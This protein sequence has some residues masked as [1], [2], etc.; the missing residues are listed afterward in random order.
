[1]TSYKPPNHPVYTTIIS[2]DSN[3]DVEIIAKDCFVRNTSSNLII[4]QEGSIT[5][6][7]SELSIK[8]QRWIDIDGKEHAKTWCQKCLD[9]GRMCMV[10]LFDLKLSVLAN[11]FESLQGCNIAN[12][13]TTVIAEMEHNKYVAKHKHA[14]EMMKKIKA[15][16]S[17]YFQLEGRTKQCVLALQSYG[18]GLL[19]AVDDYREDENWKTIAWDLERFGSI[20]NKLQEVTNVHA[21]IELEAEVIKKTAQEEFKSVEEKLMKAE[22]GKLDRGD[23]AFTAMMATPGLG[24]VAGAVYGAY[25]GAVGSYHLLDNLKCPA[26]ARVPLQF[27]AGGLGGLVGGT[28]YAIG[29]VPLVPFFLYNTL[30]G[31]AKVQ[32]SDKYETL[33][34]KFITIGAQMEMV[35]ARIKE[36]INALQIIDQKFEKSKAAEEKLNFRLNQ[37]MS[38]LDKQATRIEGTAKE[39]ISA[40][41]HYLA[42]VNRDMSPDM[43]SI[44]YAVGWENKVRKINNM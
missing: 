13:L 29:S 33:A 35:S 30:N 32:K 8:N 14:E 39:L 15:L 42:L 26:T 34:Q 2:I 4:T 5:H 37:G 17:T 43:K 22:D 25:G 20:K 24:Q 28:A 36:I 11:C 41:S 6:A 44:Q 3:S 21:T 12:S 16:A 9:H 18:E 40:C 31:V 38:L 7:I 19:D 27:I 10:C 1:V 23:L